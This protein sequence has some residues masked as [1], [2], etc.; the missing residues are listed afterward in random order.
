MVYLVVLGIDYDFIVGGI[1]HKVKSST[2]LK[3]NIYSG[4]E[5]IKS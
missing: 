2:W 3:T 1:K 4:K 5:L